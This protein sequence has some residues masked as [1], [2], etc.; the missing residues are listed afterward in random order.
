MPKY[1]LVVWDGKVNTECYLIRNREI[2]KRQRRILRQAHTG[3]INSFMP[4]MRRINVPRLRDLLDDEWHGHRVLV[5][6]FKECPRFVAQYDR[7]YADYQ[8]IRTWRAGETLTREE[9][10]NKNKARREAR[11]L[12]KKTGPTRISEML[13]QS[14][15]LMRFSLNTD[16]SEDGANNDDEEE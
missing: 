14:R 9:A 1:S 13:E 3:F 16:L 12:V 15:A 11:K 2:T 10:W 7:L 8:I 6:N 5:S 4:L